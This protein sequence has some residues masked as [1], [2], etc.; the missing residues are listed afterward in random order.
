MPIDSVSSASPS[1]AQRSNS[2]RSARMRPPLRLEAAAPAPGSPSG[3]AGAG[4][5]AP[6]PRARARATSAGATPLLRRLAA[7]VDLQA[8]L[9]AARSAGRPLRA[10]PLGDL[11]AI[12]R[13]D[14]VEVLGDDAASCCSAAGRSGATRAARAGRRSAAIFSTR[15]LHVVLAEAA[16]AG[17]VRLAHRV[18]A[19]GL[20]HG[21]QRDAFHGASGGRHKRLQCASCTWASLSAIIAIHA[22]RSRAGARLAARS[23]HHFRDE[24]WTLPN[25]WRSRSRTRPPTC[26]CRPACRR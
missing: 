9:R 20:A 11:Q 7:D 19:E 17:G 5:A 25:C 14:P 1:A 23:R 3:R 10:Q 15:F 12:D 2:A 21:E 24:P 6:R 16:L 4:A 13:V 22:P 26:T 18:G 8:H